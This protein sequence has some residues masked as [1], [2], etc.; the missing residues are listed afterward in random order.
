MIPMR[1][2]NRLAEVLTQQ[3]ALRHLTVAA[4]SRQTGIDLST[5]RR[6]ASG[7]HRSASIRTL[8]ALAQAFDCPLAAF[9]DQIG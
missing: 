4:L 1:E 8:I 9:L 7:R 3:M 6:L 5:L 2:Y